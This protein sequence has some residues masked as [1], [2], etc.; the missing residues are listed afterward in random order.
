MVVQINSFE[1][2]DDFETFSFDIGTIIL[3]TAMLIKS[4]GNWNCGF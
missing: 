2:D 1:E 4:K 3:I